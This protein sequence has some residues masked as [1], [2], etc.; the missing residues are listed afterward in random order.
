MP[1]VARTSSSSTVAQHRRSE[2]VETEVLAGAFVLPGEEAGLPDV[3]EAVP[4]PGLGD[5]LLE[6]LELAGGIRLVGRGL[7]KH[8]A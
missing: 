1:A 5:A 8:P 6:G 4:S 3:R 2:L 7:A